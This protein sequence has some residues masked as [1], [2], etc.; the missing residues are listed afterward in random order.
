MH[1]EI[2]RLETTIR[3]AQL[4]IITIGINANQMCGVSTTLNVGEAKATST[5]NARSVEGRNPVCKISRSR[6][7]GNTPTDT[8]IPDQSKG[9][10]PSAKSAVPVIIRNHADMPNLKR[11]QCIIPA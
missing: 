11:I 3:K 5:A 7:P 2:M 9:K 8:Q 4:F 6:E 1:P 10:T